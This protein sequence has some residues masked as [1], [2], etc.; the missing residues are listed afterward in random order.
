MVEGPGC[1]LKGEKL[2]STVV[3]Q[4]VKNV[5]GNVIENRPKKDQDKQT[6]YHALAGRSVIDVR[7]LGKEL[8]LFLDTGP[9]LRVHFLMSGYV[10]F[11]NQQTDPDEGARK[12]QP[13]RPRLELEMTRDVVSFYL[14]SVELRDDQET[15]DRWERMITLDV[16]WSRFDA[17]RSA[18]TIMEAR[19]EER[20]VADVIMDQEVMPGVGNIIKNEGCFD[21]G[22]NPLTKIRDL[23]REHVVT[24]VKM[25][26]DFSMIF[27]NCRKTG[28]PLHK[29]YKMYRF[30]KCK[31][32]D[33]KV[34]KCKPGEYQRGTYF[35][36][37]CQDNSLR[38][39]PTKGSLLGWAKSGVQAGSEWPQWP[40]S[41]CTLLNK[42]GSLRC[43]ACGGEK[44]PRC[45]S[46]YKSNIITQ[47]ALPQMGGKRKST[48]DFEE[49]EDAKRLR[50]E[51]EVTV[52]VTKSVGKFKFTSFRTIN[53]SEIKSDEN[54]QTIQN[55]KVLT[56]NGN[57][58]C[59]SQNRVSINDT[60]VMKD[61]P[62]VELCKGHKRPCV[63]KTVSKEGPN[64]L[65][66][67]WTCALPKAKSCNYFSWAD[68]HHPKC[69]HGDISLLREVYKMN[70]NNGREFFI[71]PRPKGRDQCDFFQWNDNK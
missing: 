6:P 11:N 41:Q 18:D 67:F 3:G 34:T 62:P 61:E 57:P 19:H 68:L 55:T 65:R 5:G 46:K 9:C 2:K 13:E 21:A 71:C 43:S 40:C 54:N 28:K 15:R 53:Q 64:K 69:R 25:L 36:P 47:L 35:C 22:I 48:G 31:Q 14:C 24:L 39:G 59:D 70:Q 52:K 7:T 51:P 8:F 10:R 4:K 1:K 29:F 38:S 45:E 12:T 30:S 37:Q 32:C 26:R 17:K 42:P 50:E 56:Q 16:C 20:L 63:K 60:N 44:E 23:S 33:S 66:L 49:S 58:L 27:Y